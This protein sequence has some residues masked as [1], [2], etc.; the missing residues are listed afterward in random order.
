MW[1]IKISKNQ[2]FIKY[3]HE[4]MKT[5]KG[6]VTSELIGQVVIEISFIKNSM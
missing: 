3:L 6:N 2:K 1:L 5:E 4:Y